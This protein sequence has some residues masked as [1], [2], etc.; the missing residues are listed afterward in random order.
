MN[1]G[2]LHFGIVS[3]FLAQIAGIDLSLLHYANIV[4]LALVLSIG[5]AGVPGGT[6]V[7][8]PIILVSIGVPPEY[9]AILYWY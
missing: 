9:I 1:G 5:T 6:L 7:M 8:M 2:A 3:V 4:F